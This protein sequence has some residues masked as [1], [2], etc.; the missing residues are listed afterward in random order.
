MPDHSPLPKPGE[1]VGYQLPTIAA[2]GGDADA[3][4]V[5]L[6]R[7]GRLTI[8]TCGQGLAVRLGPPEAAG[9]ALLLWQLAGTI[10]DDHASAAAEA[11]AHLARIQEGARNG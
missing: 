2:G 3:T 9:L 4:G 8:A 10:A 7:D 6:A 5:F 11:A 1:V